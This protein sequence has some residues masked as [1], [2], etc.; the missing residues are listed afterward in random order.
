MARH[1]WG[2]L[3]ARWDP[4]GNFLGRVST[5]VPTMVEQLD[6]HRPP[7][8]RKRHI[9]NRAVNE[10]LVDAED[11]PHDGA[12][13]GLVRGPFPG[14]AGA[15]SAASAA[16]W[17]AQ[18]KRERPAPQQD[19]RAHPGGAR[20]GVKRTRVARRDN[21]KTKMWLPA[22]PP[23]QA[24]LWNSGAKEQMLR[25]CVTPSALP[26]VRWRACALKNADGA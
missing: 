18:S 19:I 5:E 11:A 8:G 16:P 26:L 1:A 9:P 10:E 17:L 23:V 20:N 22:Q 15:A 25:G 14:A 2:N 13:M 6:D 4:R 3:G 7:R 24:R 21:T 12:S